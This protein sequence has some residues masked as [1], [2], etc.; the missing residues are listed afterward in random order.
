LSRVAGNN[1]M[2]IVTTDL[3]ISTIVNL[4]LPTQYDPF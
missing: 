4:C 2:G 3:A 1:A